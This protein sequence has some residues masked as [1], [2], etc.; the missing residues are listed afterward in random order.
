MEEEEEEEE[1]ERGRESSSSDDTPL[2][3][4]I[5][6]SSSGDNRIPGVREKPE[7]PS[8]AGSGQGSVCS[9]GRPRRLSY[10]PYDLA[11]SVRDGSSFLCSQEQLSLI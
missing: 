9:E 2:A 11:K 10:H 8:Y 5:I 6:K 1:E 4:R 7:G 3:M